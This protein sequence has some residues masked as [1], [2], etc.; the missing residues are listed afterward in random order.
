MHIFKCLCNNILYITLYTFPSWKEASVQPMTKT[1]D[2]SNPSNYCHAALTSTIS[3]PS[4]FST[5][6]SLVILNL[7]APSLIINMA[8]AR[9]KPLVVSF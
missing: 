8:S 3:S 4:L 2:C 1:V 9:L 5:P 7:V 6:T